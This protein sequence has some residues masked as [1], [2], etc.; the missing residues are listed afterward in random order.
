MS[1]DMP[2]I[3]NT[4]IYLVDSFDEIELYNGYLDG[5]ELGRNLMRLE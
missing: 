5:I 2:E 1:D 4:K 3:I